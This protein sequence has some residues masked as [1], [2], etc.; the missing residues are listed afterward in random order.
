VKKVPLRAR[1][2]IAW[3]WFKDWWR[4]ESRAA[5]APHRIG[6]PGVPYHR[7]IPIELG[8]FLH[9]DGKVYK[10]DRAGGGDLRVQD[11]GICQMVHEEY[12]VLVRI[13]KKETYLARKL[14]GLL[15]RKRAAQT[16]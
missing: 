8:F 9:T 7:P 14:Q 2:Q 11:D 3:A 13:A 6:Q 15:R 10:R 5:P 4:A 1:V 12:A 16:H